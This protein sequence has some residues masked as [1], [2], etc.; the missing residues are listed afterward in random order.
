MFSSMPT[1]AQSLD[2][3]LEKF[4][5]LGRMYQRLSLEIAPKTWR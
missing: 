2:F 3:L 1:A 4:L 5:G